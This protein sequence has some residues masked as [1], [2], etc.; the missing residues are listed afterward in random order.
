MAEPARI[1]RPGTRA[2]GSILLPN[3]WVLTP[4]GEQIDVGDLPLGMVLSPDD[5]YLVVTNNGMA[6]QF[7][8]IVD[9]ETREEVQRLPMERSWL[10]LA[11]DPL[12]DRLFVSGGGSDVVEVYR[13]DAGRAEHERTLRLHPPEDAAKPEARPAQISLQTEADFAAGLAVSSDGRTLVVCALLEHRILIFDLMSD[14]PAEGISVGE[15]PYTVV[16]HPDDQTAFVSN[17]GGQSVSVIDLKERKE[18]AQIGVGSHP[19]AMKLSPDASKLYVTNANSNEVSIIDLTRRSVGEVVDLSPYPGAPASGTTPNGLAL[20]SDGTTLFV[21]NADNND[22]AV[23]DV[24][25]SPAEI[26]GLIP[27]GWYPTAVVL[28][29]DD[30]T[31]LIANGKGLGSKPNP[32][33]PQPTDPTEGA[34]AER[35]TPIEYIGTLFPGTVSV[36]P[37]PGAQQLAKFTQQVT[38]NNGFGEMSGKLQ[39]AGVGIPPRA[40]P[41]RVGEPSPIKYVFYIVKENRTYDQ[42]LG[43]LPQGEGDPELTLFGREVTPNH[44]ALAETFV[45]FDNFYADAEVSADGHEWS[46]GAIAT[47]FVEKTWPSVYSHR[48][49]PFAYLGLNEISYPDI[50]YLWDIAAAAG[51][52][53]RSYGEFVLPGP[54]GAFTRVASLQQHYATQYPPNGDFS[55]QDV[56]RAAILIEE[57]RQFA[58][59]RRVPQLSIIS[60]PND[61]TVGTRPGSPTPRAMVADND[62][63]LGRIVEAISKSSIWHES[64]IFVVEDDAQ[65]GPDHIDSHRSI[66]LIASPY[67]K[68]GHVDHT[69]YDTVS[70]LRTIEL[71]LGLPPM[72]QYDAAAIPMF[73]AFQDRADLTPYAARP[74]QISL[75]ERNSAESYG[76][77]LSMRMNWEAVDDAPEQLLNEIIWKSV[78]GAASEMPRPHTSRGRSTL[79]R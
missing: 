36:L 60:L 11:F 22:V 57:I 78:K 15:H 4:A 2:D 28:T 75:D 29:R 14:A 76:A 33:G 47:D 50:G 16:I 72:S 40:I 20:S 30:E 64:A 23:I 18:I 3:H 21:V 12:G 9:L 19:N 58:A 31:L 45:L 41:R 37:V 79:D 24:S 51:V 52:S 77:E 65:N 63:A 38:R 74:N 27:T 42:I 13:F 53:Y 5:R 67:A 1:Q 68:R 62:L 66:A 35:A 39:S 49:M 6:D 26:R 34:G 48:R 32:R 56:H 43:D 55:V 69:M 44:H 59:E 54:Q 71:I 25:K 70:M 10:G 7:V 73:D 46:M 17:W 61:H 8:S